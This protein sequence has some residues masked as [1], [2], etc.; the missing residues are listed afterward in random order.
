MFINF[1]ERGREERETER[2]I[3]VREKYWQV[4]SCIHSN[5]GPNPQPRHM[6][7]P[8]IVPVTFQFTSKGWTHSYILCPQTPRR[9]SFYVI[10]WCNSNTTINSWMMGYQICYQIS[11]WDMLSYL[12]STVSNFFKTCTLDNYNDY[13]LHLAWVSFQ[14]EDCFQ[15]QEGCEYVCLPYYFPT[16]CFHYKF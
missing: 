1:G 9:Q 13:I 4:A 10:L 16:S 3:D 7:W 14:R 6:P 11:Q 12:L 8:G 15:C 2:N 5:Q